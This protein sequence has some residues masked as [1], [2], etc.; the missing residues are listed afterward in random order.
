MFNDFGGPICNTNAF[1]NDFGCSIYKTSA[2]LNICERKHGKT[3]A[4]GGWGSFEATHNYL[5]TII[6]F[7][8]IFIYI[9]IYI[10]STL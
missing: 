5:F 4:L 8:L 1:F 10:Y 6:F 9:Y 2:F 7:N 3:N